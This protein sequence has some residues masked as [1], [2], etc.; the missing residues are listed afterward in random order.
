[1][2]AER[3]CDDWATKIV[4]YSAIKMFPRWCYLTPQ[5]CIVPVVTAPSQQVAEL[6]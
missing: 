2:N 4:N 6:F 1:M 5:L 3:I